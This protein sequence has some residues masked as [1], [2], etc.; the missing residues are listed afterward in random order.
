MSEETR[1]SPLATIEAFESAA[2]RSAQV[3]R[4]LLADHPDLSVYEIRP[5][6]ATSAYMQDADMGKLEIS[7]DTVDDVRAWAEVLGAEVEITVHADIPGLKT[8][9]FA[10]H[11]CTARIA[12]VEVK[13]IDSRELTEDEVAAWRAEQGQAAA[14]GGEAE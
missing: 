9:P 10:I 11:R 4:Q 12:G 13:V 3:A 7:T 8:Q 2:F 1:R 14:E 5:Y 6:A